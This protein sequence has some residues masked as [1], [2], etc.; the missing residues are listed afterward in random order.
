MSR[1]HGTRWMWRNLKKLQQEKNPK[2]LMTNQ[3]Q[4]FNLNPKYSKFWQSNSTICKSQLAQLVKFLYLNK[5][6][7]VQMLEILYKVIMEE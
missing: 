1:W 3:T 7:E 6:S 5:K 2:F 4:L